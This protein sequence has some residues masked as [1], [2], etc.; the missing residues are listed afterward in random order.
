MTASLTDTEEEF[1]LIFHV[2]FLGSLVGLALVCLVG[3]SF[4]YREL[5]RFKG[6]IVV[7]APFTGIKRTMPRRNVYFG[8]VGVI[9]FC[10][11]IILSSGWK[12]IESIYELVQGLPMG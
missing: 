10:S 7:H 9:T 5:K 2:V 6:R 4:R 3:T 12:L 11:F 8:V 1:E